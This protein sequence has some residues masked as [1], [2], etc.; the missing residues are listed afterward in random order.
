M[1]LPRL[2]QHDPELHAR[3]EC[4]A[5]ARK[6]YT[7]SFDKYPR[8][9]MSAELPRAEEAPSAWNKLV[10]GVVADVV[11]NDFRADAVLKDPKAAKPSRLTELK[12]AWK[13]LMGGEPAEMANDLIALLVAGPVGGRAESLEQFAQLFQTL[14]L[15]ALAANF[16]E[17]SVFS[18]KYLCGSD[19]EILERVTT[20]DPD[21]AITDAHLAAVSPGDTLAAAMAEGRLFVADYGMLDTLVPN[22]LG[23]PRRWVLAPR[24]AFVVPPGAGTLAVFAIQ[25]GRKPAAD[26][27]VFTPAHGWGWTIAKTHASVAD[28]IAGAIWFH[29]ART[30]LI[31]EPIA[32]AAHRQLAPNHP[33]LQLLTPHFEGTLYINSVGHDTVFAPHGILDWFTGATR[34][35]IR[36]LAYRSVQSFRFDDSI[37]PRRLALRGVDDS[38]VLADFPWRDDGLL[39]FGALRRWVEEYLGVYYTSDADVT[40]DTEL[41]AW[42]AE[43]VASD[44]G[45]LLG[46]GQDGGIHTRA[47][48]V[49]FL[50]QLIFSGS[51]LHAAMNFP[52]MDEMAYVP[53]SPFGAYAD[54]PTRTD[55]WTEQDWLAVLPPMDQ[56][57]RQMDVAWLLGACRYGKLGDYASGHFADPRIAPVLARFKERLAEV[58]STIDDRNT[59]RTPYI[60]LKPSRVPQSINI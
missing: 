60:H 26:N 7:F 23:G 47:Y 55:G 52:V 36:D 12:V 19:P 20:L 40:D 41:Q 58:E 6:R 59:H 46:I 34:E 35:S 27:P 30:H 17:D 3:A 9:A 15:P 21:F 57:Q 4:L 16:L 42:M 33:V 11:K 54:R 38:K 18:R 45:G 1:S 14:P 31:A 53:N 48:L 29:H 39:V 22:D 10:F 37:F 8:L 43:I 2:P 32:V 49:D 24:V 5:D 50:T 25:I 51:A 44:G 56:A 13:S 28:T